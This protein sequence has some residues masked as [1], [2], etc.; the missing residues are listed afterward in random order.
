MEKKNLLVIDDNKS[1][2]SL[3]KDYFKELKDINVV[4]TANDGEEGINLIQKE[5]DKYNIIILDIVMP[6]IDGIE[7]LKY[8]QKNHINKKIIV[9]TSCNSQEMIRKVTELGADYYILKPFLFKNLE[10]VIRELNHHKILGEIDLYQ[11][12]LERTIIYLLHELGV[13][14]HIKGYQYMKEGI[15]II[16]HNEITAKE[17]YNKIAKTF[18]STTSSVERAIRH[19]IEISWNRGNYEVMEEIFGYSIDLDKAKPTNREYLITITDKIKLDYHK[20]I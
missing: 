14:S 13:P 18:H 7:V 2:I 8:I 20:P 5:M 4:L 16:Y 1:I 12:Q 19:A 17:L 6:N 15:K 10:R 9:L 11:N 3:I